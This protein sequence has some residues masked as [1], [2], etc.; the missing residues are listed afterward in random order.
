MYRTVFEEA[1]MLTSLHDKPLVVVTATESLAEEGWSELQD[2]LAALSTNSRHRVADATHS[3]VVDDKAGCESS[4]QAI[5][6]V[7]HSVRTH[8]PVAAR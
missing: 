1:K 6:D 7:V 8:E 4:V 3:G 5:L 2:R